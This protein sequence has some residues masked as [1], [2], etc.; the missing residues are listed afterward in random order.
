MTRRIPM[1]LLAAAVLGA[2]NI[3]AQTLTTETSGN[4]RFS[5]KTQVFMG[6]YLDPSSN[7][8]D[9]VPNAPTGLNFGIEFP[10]SRQR[11]WQQY[12]NDPTVGLGISYLNMGNDVMGEGIAMYPYIM[13]NALRTEHFHAKV[14]LA[15]GLVAVNGHYKATIKEEIPNRTFGSCINAYLS[16]GLNLDF[17]ISRNFAINSELGFYHISNGR[18]VEP[19]KGSNILYGGIGLIA[20]I[21]PE[22]GSEKKPVHFP[23]LPYKWSLNITGAAGVQNADLDDSRK[24]FI[25]TFHVGGIYSTT[26][27]HGIG[28][29]LD[30]F[31]NDAVSNE[32]DRGLFCK[33]R[34]YTTADKIRVGL[35]LDNEF[36][37]GD[38]TA[39]LDWGVYL[40]NPSRHYFDY[41]HKKYGH[42]SRLPLFYNSNGPGSQEAFHYIRFGLKYRIWDNMYLQAL[43]KTHLHICEYIEFGIGYQIPF[44]SKDKRKGR[45]SKIFH[46]SKDWWIN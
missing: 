3:K 13:I 31:F 12:L 2:S 16:G 40:I 43:A 41:D 22:C 38:V 20:T 7:I 18:T 11:P 5:F 29:G 37:F 23:D 32:T 25:S 9:I 6:K 21:N 17:P 45:D 4:D 36:K 19:N 24:F 8:E 35:S 39:M 42:D 28:L 44:F 30:V 26:N 27:W 14:K 15:A 1:L 10:S 33:E 46:H 34:D